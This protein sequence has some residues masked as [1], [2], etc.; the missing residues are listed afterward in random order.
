MT[1]RLLPLIALTAVIAGA[2]AAYAA[3]V[4]VVNAS[5]ELPGV[6]ATPP[7][8]TSGVIQGWQVGGVGGVWAPLHFPGTYTPPSGQQV[9]YT[10][11]GSGSIIFQ[12][13]GPVVPGADYTLSVE[14]GQRGDFPLFDYRLLL[15]VWGPGGHDLATATVFAQASDGAGSPPPGSFIPVTLTGTD[16]TNLAG[17]LVIFLEGGN[18]AAFGTGGQ[19]GWDNVALSVTTIPEPA[20]LAA[21]WVGLLG[22]AGLRRASPHRK[23]IDSHGNATTIASATASPAR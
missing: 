18:S 3:N 20:S 1:Y 17:D 15:G 21:F 14:V 12:D 2:P 22:L 11:P 23:P 4:P 13:V 16:P 10:G 7:F 5:F 8:V 9:G 6:N 19:A